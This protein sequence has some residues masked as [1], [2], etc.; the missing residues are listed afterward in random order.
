[1]INEFGSDYEAIYK[2]KTGIDYSLLITNAS[3]EHLYIYEKVV[4]TFPEIEILDKAYNTLFELLPDRRAV[5]FKEK[6]D[7]QL[8]QKFWRACDEVKQ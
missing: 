4:P 8:L 7:M 2:N 6:Y 5:V 1:M 3:P